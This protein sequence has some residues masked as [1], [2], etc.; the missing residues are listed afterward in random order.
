MLMLTYAIKCFAKILKVKK[1]HLKIF[2]KQSLDT[3]LNHTINQHL[4]KLQTGYQLGIFYSNK[5]LRN[6]NKNSCQFFVR[7]RNI[8][9]YFFLH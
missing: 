4:R 8:L 5:K 9:F 6:L 7:N 3:I 2:L 1:K